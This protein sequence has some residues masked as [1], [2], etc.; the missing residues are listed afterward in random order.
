[1]T[2][3]LLLHQLPW[4]GHYGI[5]GLIDQNPAVSDWQIRCEGQAYLRPSLLFFSTRL[6]FL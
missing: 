1:M 5:E 4:F 3:T 6:I 2:I